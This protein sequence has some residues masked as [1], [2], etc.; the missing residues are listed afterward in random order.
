MEEALSIVKHCMAHP[1]SQ[2]LRIELV[3][4][5]KCEQTWYAAK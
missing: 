5:A 3:V 4:D 1:F 2:P